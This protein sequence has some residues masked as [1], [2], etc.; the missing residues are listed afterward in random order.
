MARS[1]DEIL[2]ALVGRGTPARGAPEAV[3]LLRAGR[4][5]AAERALPRA[6][7]RRASRALRAGRKGTFALVFDS[8]FRPQPA[9][10]RS[11]TADAPRFLRFEGAQTIELEISAVAR[12]VRVLGQVEP[13]GSIARITIE[14]ESKRVER[15]VAGD[16][17]FRTPVLPRGRATLRADGTVVGELPL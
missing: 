5:V 15:T 6:W 7:L 9:L 10:R 3:R 8:W 4:A 13:P 17:T 11:P 14:T 16:G 12:G 1:F 2:E